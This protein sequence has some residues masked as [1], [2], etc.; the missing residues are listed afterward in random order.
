MSVLIV[1]GALAFLMFAAYRGFSVILVAPV[2]AVMAILLTAP[3]QV[4]PTFTGVFLEA[5]AGFLKTYFPVFMLG[6]IFGKLMEFAG[7]STAIARMIARM[8]GPHRAILAT[9]LMCAVM[10]YGGVSLFVVVFTV[11]P[12]AAALFREAD[13]PKRLIPGAVALGAFTFSMDSIPGSPQIQNIIPTA[14]FGTTTWAAPVLGLCG[15]GLIA[16]AGLSYLE[17]RRRSAG[18]EGYGQNHLN[19]PAP[20]PEGKL[21]NGGVALLPL[22]LVLAAN[23]LL[24][25]AIPAFYGKA[26]AFLST[27][28][29]PPAPLP[30]A[31]VTGVW[32]VEGALLLGCLLTLALGWRLIAP[33]FND[34]TKTA[35]GGAMLASVNTASEFGFGA[36]IA[37][38][39]GFSMIR[40]ALA[41]IGDP[42]VREAVTVTTLAGVT[43]SGS[44]GLSIALA[45]MGSKFLA[46]G[47]AAGIPPQ[48]LHRI[49]AMACGGMDTLPH[50]GAVITLLAVCGLTHRQSYKDIF[51]L[52]GIKTAAAFVVIGLYYATHLV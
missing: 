32:A 40:G 25:Q 49:A 45:A 18:A 36:V 15:G 17:W 13:I 3:D 38:L 50:N 46:D 47:V 51:A 44:G 12:L 11:Y 33:R 31:S 8:V 20:V 43:G 41:Q 6:A 21:V 16:A 35:I 2:A 9:V 7:L 30:I 22:L 19:E 5:M 37:V 52:T 48:V 27:A 10:T 26:A 4:A 42:L 14:F 29:K 1:L 39:P 34:G 24:T 28:A 23:L